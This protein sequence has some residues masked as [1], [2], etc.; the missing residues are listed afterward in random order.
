MATVDVNGHSVE[1]DE[2]GFM[3]NLDEWNE[4]VAVYLAKTEDVAELTEDHWKLVN[5]LKDYYKEYGIA[6]M[7]RK[8]CKDTGLKL[9]EIYDLFPTGPAKGACKVAGLPKPTGCV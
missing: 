3:V 4:E 6:P 1:L 9:K 2:D 7:V 8:M 5:Y